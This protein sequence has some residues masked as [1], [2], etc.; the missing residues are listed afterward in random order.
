M[1]GRYPLK[2]IQLWKRPFVNDLIKSNE[3]KGKKVQIRLNIYF[4]CL[5]E[6]FEMQLFLLQDISK[7]NYLPCLGLSKYD[8][9]HFWMQLFPPTGSKSSC[10]N[11][12]WS[13]GQSTGSDAGDPS[14]ESSLGGDDRQSERYDSLYSCHAGT[15]RPAHIIRRRI[16]RRLVHRRLE[17]FTTNFTAYTVIPRYTAPDI[18][19]NSL[20]ATNLLCT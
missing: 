8:L 11:S 15:E 17:Q 7:C 19:P 14:I 10:T 9:T 6:I 2:V 1:L 16:I 3:I 4:S 18:L 20:I 13:C 5:N 12:R